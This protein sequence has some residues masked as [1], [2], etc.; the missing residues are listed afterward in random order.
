[1]QIESGN[2]F[3]EFINEFKDDISCDFLS[4]NEYKEDASCADRFMR[5]LCLRDVYFI[6]ILKR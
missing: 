3:F 2:V 5:F 4:I 6:N 1:M